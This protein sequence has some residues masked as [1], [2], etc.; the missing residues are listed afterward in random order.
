M[1]YAA[2]LLESPVSD[3]DLQTAMAE[4]DLNADGK[5]SFKEFVY[6]WKRGR[7]GGK[8]VYKLTGKWA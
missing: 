4:M 3:E 2:E 7:Q 8:S 5:I 1:K 6:W